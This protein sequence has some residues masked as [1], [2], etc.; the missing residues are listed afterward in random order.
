MGFFAQLGKTMV[1]GSA[2]LIPGTLTLTLYTAQATEWVDVY[3]ITIVSNETTSRV[4]TVSD[5]TTSLTYLI[6]GTVGGSNPPVIDQGSIPVRFKK[7]AVLTA[8]ASSLTVSTTVVV[9][10]RALVSKT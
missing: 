2:V 8:T 1:N 3:S 6:G 5:G 4:I 7:G 9:N 10:I